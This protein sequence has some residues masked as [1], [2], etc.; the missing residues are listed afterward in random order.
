[1]NST[2]A[3]KFM[4]LYLI[5]VSVMDAWVAT[6]PAKR[7]AAEDEMK[8]EWHDWMVANAQAIISTEAC[9]KTK[10]VTASGIADTRNDITL[11]SIVEAESHEAA[12]KLFE[13]HPHL[14]I[15]QSSIEIMEIRSLGGM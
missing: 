5:P 2:N 7:K 1:M 3:K 11:Y 6:D 9:G 4:A 10:S 14:Q 15:P 12:A 8:G 13:N